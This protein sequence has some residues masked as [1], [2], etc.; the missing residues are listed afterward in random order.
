[1]VVH[2]SELPPRSKHF[3]TLYHGSII[4]HMASI[5]RQGIKRGTIDR[6]GQVSRE[7][8]IIGSDRIMDCLGTVSMS[9][10]QKDA[11]FFAA[12]WQMKPRGEE[13]GQA[14]FEIDPKQLNKNNMYFR[15]MFGKRYAEV[16]YIGDIPPK[17]IKRVFIRRF[18]WTEDDFIVDEYYKTCEEILKEHA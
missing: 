3:D 4:E 10:N 11:I 8:P 16:K 18:K 13:R 14:I 9:K 7:D 12:S 17:A 6:V 1:M 2:Y 15:D 5:C